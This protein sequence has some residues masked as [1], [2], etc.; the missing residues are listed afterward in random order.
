MIGHL[1]LDYFYAQVEEVMDPTL[2]GR[3]VVVCVFSGR[4]EDSG[5]VS[6]A[7]YVAREFGVRSGIPI[8]LAKSKLKGKNPALIRMERDKYEQV[9]DRIMEL[10]RA[11]VDVLE[12]TGIDEAF[13]DITKRAGDDYANAKSFATE[14]KAAILK[15][16]GLTCSV[17]IGRSKVVAKIASDY[18]KPDGL[19]VVTPAA[20][21]GFLRPLPVGK[22]YGVGP[23]AGRTL[24]SAGVR[25][26][27]ELAATPIELLESQFGRKT[28]V[29]LHVAATGD[30]D[31]PVE[32]REKTQFSR[33]ITL[34]NDTADPDLA[35]TE[36]LPAIEDLH[37]K[38]A[39]NRSSFRVISVIGILTDLSIKTKSYTLESPL[40]DLDTMKAESRRLLAALAGSVGREFRR[41]GVRVSGLVETEGQTSMTA[42]YGGEQ[43]A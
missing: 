36:L 16:E 4:T 5:V 31:E 1:D 8:T 20:T 19:T 15:A 17:G 9:S 7:N 23:K 29:Y 28:A 35:F 27:G 39:A 42:Y 11:D 37:A 40:D 43:P 2:K 21:T 6:T 41:I 12:Q 26:L 10:I 14:L 34:K 3:P 32:E 38:L 13:M 33:I 18:H 30:D 22:M 25:T 24:E